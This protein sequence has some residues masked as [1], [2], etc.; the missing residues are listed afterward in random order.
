MQ[1]Q[2]EGAIFPRRRSLVRAFEIPALDQLK[3]IRLMRVFELHDADILRTDERGQSS[4][5]FAEA[6]RVAQRALEK[7]ELRTAGYDR[8]DAQPHAD[9]LLLELQA[10]EMRVQNAEQHLGI[11]RGRWDGEDALIAI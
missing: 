2:T 10:F 6:I 1:R 3:A 5:R 4:E 11:T 7:L 9:G 8:F